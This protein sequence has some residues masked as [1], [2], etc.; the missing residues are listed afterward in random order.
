MRNMVSQ[1]MRNV[2]LDT[3]E[4][5]SAAVIWG[6]CAEARRADEAEHPPMTDAASCTRTGLATS[7]ASS[8]VSVAGA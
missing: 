8:S 5:D 1:V 2:T 3:D 4:G 6:L 7:P